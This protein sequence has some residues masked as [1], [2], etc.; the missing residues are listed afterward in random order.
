MQ[1]LYAK[2]CKKIR[3]TLFKTS[4]SVL[5]NLSHGFIFLIASLQGKRGN[6]KKNKNLLRMQHSYYCQF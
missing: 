4:Y 6:N 5:N 2:D 3:Y 1:H